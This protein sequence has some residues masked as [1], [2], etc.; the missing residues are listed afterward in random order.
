MRGVED[1]QSPID[2]VL[3]DGFRFE[4][5]AAG[6]LKIVV[7]GARRRG[8]PV[9]CGGVVAPSVLESARFRG[10]FY[11]PTAVFASRDWQ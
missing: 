2:H 1:P 6:A 7:E 5:V 3:Y 9:M 8:G 10:T 4:H 11:S